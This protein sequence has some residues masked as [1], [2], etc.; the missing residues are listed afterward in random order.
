MPRGGYR[1]GAGRP[2]GS[3]T[4]AKKAVFGPDYAAIFG[5]DPIPPALGEPNSSPAGR[6]AGMPGEPLPADD[7]VPAWR[8]PQK[9][10]QMTPLEYALAV[11]RDHT[12]PG[13]RRD[14][15]CAILLPYLH[16]RVAD[17]RP[18][19]KDLK[20][21]AAE[22]ASQSRFAPSAPPKLAAVK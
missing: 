17:A 18:T 4:G 7:V 13:D 5:G 21:E 11:M 3:K 9:V 14:R 8:D 10:V 19:K 1:P 16:K 12:V 22:R 20:E 2:K 6:T 15:L